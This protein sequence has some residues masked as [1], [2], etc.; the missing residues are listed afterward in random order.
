MKTYSVG[1]KLFCD[2]HFSGK[3]KAV[4]IAVLHSGNGKDNKGRVRVRISEDLGAY[5]KGEELEIDTFTAVPRKQEFRK[6]GSVFRW[7]DTNY[8]WK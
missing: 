8:T 6:S 4:C 7:V 2:F 3:P 5:H 1:A